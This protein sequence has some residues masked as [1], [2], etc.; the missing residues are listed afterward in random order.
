MISNED[1][2]YVIRQIRSIDWYTMRITELEIKLKKVSNQHS[3]EGYKSPLNWQRIKIQY[4]DDDG[5]LVEEDARYKI[6]GSKYPVD[7]KGLMFDYED[8]LATEL[9][10]MRY[11][12]C[13]AMSY[14]ESLKQSDEIDFIQDFF[15]N[16]PYEKLK[17]TYNISNVNRHMKSLIK[18]Q[19]KSI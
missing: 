19:I 6:P 3:S 14:F 10:A 15:E 13:K 4:K 18:Q 8:E 11:S 9:Q 2:S 1:A 12:L 5:N 17:M 16:K 7:S